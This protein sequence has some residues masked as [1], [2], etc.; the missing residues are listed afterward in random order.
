MI[1]P[2]NHVPITKKVIGFSFV[3]AVVFFG[4]CKKGDTGPAGSANVLYSD[5]FIATPW[6]QTT[7]FSMKNF[8]YT[9]AAPGITQ[10][11]LDSGIV[12][13]F[14]KLTGYNTSV[15]PVGQVGQLPINLTYTQ[16]SIQ[17]DTWS[18]FATLGNLRINFV[19]NVNTY[20]NISTAHSFRYIIVPGAVKTGR[21]VDLRSMSYDEVC[22]YLNIPR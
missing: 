8:D 2:V 7:V 22:D 16:G 13:T 17:T 5:W 15:W 9:K 6:A 1:F 18:A 4:A 11:V 10:N 3:L 21:R 20:S 14:G 12:L 19:N